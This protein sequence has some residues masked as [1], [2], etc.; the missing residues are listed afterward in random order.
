MRLVDSLLEFLFPDRN[1]CMLCARPPAPLCR[2]C[3]ERVQLG[4]AQWVRVGW[5]GVDRVVALW[6]YEG[7]VRR[8]VQSMKFLSQPYLARLFATAFGNSGLLEQLAVDVVTAVPMHRSRFLQRGYNQAALLAVELALSQ[9]WPYRELLVRV[10]NTLPQHTLTS[11]ARQSNLLGAFRAT[12]DLANLR[13]LLVDDVLTTGN[14]VRACAETLR[15]AG[16]KE[17]VVLVLAI[18]L[19]R[20]KNY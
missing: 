12:A 5:Q 9:G 11:K 6:P 8:Q 14:T 10:K 18:A 16:A 4:Q 3:H 20:S 15:A 17:V 13:V 2:S 7:Q 1:T 19:P